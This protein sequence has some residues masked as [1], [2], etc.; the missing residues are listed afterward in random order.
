MGVSLRR[1]SK[2]ICFLGYG[3]QYHLR[4]VC[5]DFEYCNYSIVNRMRAMRKVMITG[6][7]VQLSDFSHSKK[8]ILLDER[9]QA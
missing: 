3:P 4:S 8:R 5:A 9:E 6:K 2:E 1:R 7:I